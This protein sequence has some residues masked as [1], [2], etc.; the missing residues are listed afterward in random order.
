[1]T[2]LILWRHAEA[3]EGTNDLI[4]Q[5]TPK[6]HKQAQKVAHF[7]QNKLPEHFDLYVSQAAR[8][9]QTGA[10]LANHAVI[11]DTINPETNAQNLPSLI[12]SLRDKKAVVIVGHQPWLGDLCA[13][14]LNGNFQ[15]QHMWSIKKGAFWWLQLNFHENDIFAK[16]KMVLTPNDI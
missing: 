4:R 1:M 6:G 10:Y 5:L 12:L 2:Q 15:H 16:T 7:L 13:F 9:Q 3:E 14:L 11:L 8:S